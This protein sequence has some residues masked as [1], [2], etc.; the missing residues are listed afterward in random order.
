M[1]AKTMGRVASARWCGAHSS[2]ELLASSHVS[3]CALVYGA[4]TTAR[5]TGLPQVPAE[6]RAIEAVGATLD[7]TAAAEDSICVQGDSEVQ[8][9]DL[10]VLLCPCAYLPV[11]IEGRLIAHDR[12]S[13]SVSQG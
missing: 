8:E 3:L 10:R 1:A 6:A 12:R 7:E 13:A 4:R 9:L 5:F 2:H 11:V